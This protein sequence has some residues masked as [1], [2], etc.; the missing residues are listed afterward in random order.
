MLVFG[1]FLKLTTHSKWKNILKKRIKLISEVLLINIFTYKQGKTQ[2]VSL[3]FGN[4]FPLQ[5]VLCL[6]L[7][8][9]FY[10]DG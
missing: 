2:N 8:L 6:L 7:L 3:M 4:A 10:A 9:F 1:R 5:V